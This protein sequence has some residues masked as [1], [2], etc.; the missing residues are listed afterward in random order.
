MAKASAGTTG[1]LPWLHAPRPLRWLLGLLLTLPLLWAAL[2]IGYAPVPVPGRWLLA[3]LFAVFS[4]WALW[5]A[6]RRWPV[7]VAALLFAALMV[8]WSFVRPSHDR[9]WRPEIAVMPRIDVD[10]DQIRISGYRHF[11]YRTR[12]EFT[13][14]WEERQLRLSD[15]QGL[16]FFVSYW[17][18]DGAIAHTFVSFDFAGV[19]P[20]AISIEIRPEVGESFHPVQGLFRHFE[21][22][23]VVGDERDIVA[24]RSNHRDEE[25]FLYRTRVS[26]ESA[27]RLFL[28]YAERINALAD[29]PEFYNVVS[30]NC[31]VNIVR[32]ANRIGRT[33]G[34]DI[35]HLL[36][37][38]SDRYLYDAG[39][40]DTS[41][42]FAELRGRSRINEIAHGAERDPAFSRRIRE[43]RPVPPALPSLPR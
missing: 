23:Y 30:N 3:G 43:G 20:V 16:D 24:V 7:V 13:G 10:G 37:G 22:V 33:G 6:S 39:L 36:N 38:W 35:R 18:P 42:P 41:M 5:R 29:A 4:L 12:D 21:L 15:L 17:N 1:P 2:A 32:Y 25:V 34:W 8:G 19:D 14:R 40:I 31:T 11:E 9:P 26:A 28:V 27:R